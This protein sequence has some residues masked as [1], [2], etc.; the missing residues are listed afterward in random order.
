MASGVFLP[1]SW[2]SLARVY[3]DAGSSPILPD[4]TKSPYAT[5][6]RAWTTRSGILS[7]SKWVIFSRKW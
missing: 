4:A 1:A 3:L 7:L 5:N 6:P 2:N